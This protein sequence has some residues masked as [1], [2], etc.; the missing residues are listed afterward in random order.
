MWILGLYLCWF[1]ALYFMRCQ[2]IEQASHGGICGWVYWT[3]NMGGDYSIA[4]NINILNLEIKSFKLI[5]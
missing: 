2:Q 4:K 1:I 3:C 5:Y